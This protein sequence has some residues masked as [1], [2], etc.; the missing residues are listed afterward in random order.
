MIRHYCDECGEELSCG[1]FINGRNNVRIKI[2]GREY[3]MTA[4]ISSYPRLNSELP[5][6]LREPD[7]CRECLRRKI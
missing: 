3:T 5:P 1:D 7:I 4:E 2:K 6:P